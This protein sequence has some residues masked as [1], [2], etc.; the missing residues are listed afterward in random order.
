MH[1]FVYVSTASQDLTAHQI[2]DIAGTCHRNNRKAGLTG[3]LLAHQG[4]FLHILEG[5]EAAIRRRAQKIQDD[6]RHR[7][8]EVLQAREIQM[9]AFTDWVF[10]HE[11]PEALPLLG[12]ENIAPLRALLPINSA[13]RGRDLTVRHLVRD[14]LASFRQLLA[15]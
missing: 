10:V 12:G 7:D 13:L 3:M 14:F 9:R 4:R 6:P 5:D 15:A 11:T 1:R 8:F 2:A